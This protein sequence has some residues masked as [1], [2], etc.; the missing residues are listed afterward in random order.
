MCKDNTVF[1][2][3]EKSQFLLTDLCDT[4]GIRGVVKECVQCLIN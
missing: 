3:K 2:L 1:S 4:L